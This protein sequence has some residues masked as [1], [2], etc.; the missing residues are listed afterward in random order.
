VIESLEASIAQVRR[1]AL[2]GE[3]VADDDRI[4]RL[5]AD[6]LCLHG[7]RHD[8]AEFARAVRAALEEDGVEVR[9]FGAAG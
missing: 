9:P 2:H 5:R 6:T 1:L 8:A 7:D 4:V 3:V